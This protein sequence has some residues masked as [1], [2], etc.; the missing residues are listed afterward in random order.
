MTETTASAPLS[1]QDTLVACWNAVARTSFGATVVQSPRAIVATF[2]AF[3]PMNNAIMLGAH[4]IDLAAETK[5]L[6]IAYARAG[7][8]SWAVWIPSRVTSFE[9]EDTIHEID[10]LKRDTTT[11]VMETNSLMS[12]RTSTSA[13]PASIATAARAGDEPVPAIALGEPSTEEGL[14]GWVFVDHDV[15]VAGV[16]RFLHGTDCGIYAVGTAPAWRR[17]GIARALVEHVLADAARLGARTA[18]LQSTPMAQRLYESLGFVPV[19]RY[20]E[21]TPE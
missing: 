2:P 5:K 17:R 3:E 21:W 18:T 6:R 12:F 7:V 16:Y 8:P 11:L 15:A 13:R 10:G 1:G 4:D 20:E 19:G 14:A 9:A